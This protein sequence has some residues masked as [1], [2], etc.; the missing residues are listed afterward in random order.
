MLGGVH[1]YYLISQNMIE[2]NDTRDASDA[3]QKLREEESPA[4]EP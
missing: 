2:D 4:V 3:E 1:F